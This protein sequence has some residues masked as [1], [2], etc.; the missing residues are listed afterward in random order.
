MN[1]SVPSV[2]SVL[3]VAMVRSSSL[4]VRIPLMEFRVYLCRRKT[5]G[6]S[7]YFARSCYGSM[8]NFPYGQHIPKGQ[9]AHPTRADFYQSAKSVGPGLLYPGGQADFP[10]G[11]KFQ[12]RPLFI[13]QR[14]PLTKK[15]LFL[16]TVVHIERRSL[17]PRSP[18]AHPDR[19]R[20]RR[21]C[22]ASRSP[23]RTAGFGRHKTTQFGTYSGR[24]CYI[25]ERPAR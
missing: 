24:C 7:R 18:A 3:S 12:T 13:L 6:P 17:S 1:F 20:G 22:F 21:C 2:F 9:V 23:A 19:R 8:E 11:I 16:F 14:L 15:G 10:P 25:P 5:V 4:V